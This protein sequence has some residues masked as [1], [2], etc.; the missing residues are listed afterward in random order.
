L[1]GGKNSVSQIVAYRTLKV[2]YTKAGLNMKVRF[3]ELDK[4]LELSN[5]GETDG[6]LS[7]IEIISQ[8]YPNLVRVPVSIYSIQAIALSLDK[9]IF[10]NRW[11]DLNKYKFTIIK[12][13]K[14]IEIA[15]KNMNKNTVLSY[16]MVFSD[17]INHKSDVIVIPRL[18]AL[19]SIYDN[20]YKN[21]KIVSK[22]LQSLKL[23]HFVNKKNIDIIPLLTPILKKMEISGEINYWYKSYL[24]S[25][26]Q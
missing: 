10:L 1:S 25:I 6:E 3:L 2:A 19:K 8:F 16:S 18:V 12:G 9:N 14:F 24:N 7:R 20:H 21:V 4:S 23:Y 22:S 26:S 15:T 5:S 13:V 17:L 11:S